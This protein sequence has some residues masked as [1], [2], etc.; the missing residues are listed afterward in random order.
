LLDR[1]SR[2]VLPLVG[3]VLLCSTAWPALAQQPAA[4]ASAPAAGT[5]EPLD[6]ELAR[7]VEDEELV[8]TAGAAP[9]GSVVGDIP[10]EITLGPREIRA[11]GA[12][13]VAELLEALEPQIGSSRGRGGRPVTLVN[14]GRISD[15]REIRD[16]PP[17]AILRVDIHPEEVALKYGYPADQRVVNFVLRRRFRAI[18]AE[19]GVRAPTQ[20]G[21]EAYDLDLNQLRIGGDT[22]LQ[23]DLKLNRRTALL[24]S[25]RDILARSSGAPFSLG[26]NVTATRFGEEIDPALSTQAGRSLTAVGIPSGTRSLA[27]FAD[28][29]AT[30]TG[31]GAFRTLISPS[32][33]AT[34]NA[35][36]SRPLGNG[37]ALTVNGEL[38]AS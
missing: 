4:P 31:E 3:S 27:G 15:F 11:L 25:E 35:I 29:P 13:S 14:G 19:A 24:E 22:R 9:T 34:L 17:E 38:E 30:T 33:S 37:V 5:E 1:R 28:A 26:G 18:T 32:T 23:L 21:Q 2:G 36:L 8:V 20:G 16:L 6:P 10:P 7:E 12:S